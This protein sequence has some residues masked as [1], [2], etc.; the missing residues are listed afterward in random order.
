MIQIQDVR[1]TYGK[2][3]ALESVRLDIPRG[4]CFGLVGPNGAGK[5]TLMKILV[6]VVEDYEGEVLVHGAPFKHNVLAIKRR[7][8]YVPQD[9]CLEETLTARDNLLFFGRL[10]GLKGAKL[11][12][13]M[14]QVLALIG[15][16]DREKTLVKTFSGGMKRRLNIG[17]ALLH[18]PDIIVLDEP[19]VGVDPQ[20]RRAI[21]KLIHDLKAQDKTIL[22]SSHYMEEVE[23]LCDT[24]G[25]IDQGNVVE[26]GTMQEVL[27]KH[28][29]AAI[30]LEGQQ[31]TR[32][33]LN[34]YEGVTVRDKG[35]VI[36][37]AEPLRLLER[38]ANQFA[39]E[40]I[41]PERLELSQ[42]KL[43]DI[44][45]KLTGSPLRDTRQEGIQ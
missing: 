23:Q 36:E 19:T 8:G 15:L 17:C 26:C 13:R 45:F 44:F 2:R 32:E 43:E 41:V 28:R 20:S 7:I 33:R 29:H 4:S 39:A 12:Q 1:K 5:S 22:Y 14:Q 31:V 25:F 30:Y 9:I 24:I 40:A 38:L 11:R 18:D 42:A 35:F 10:Y 16:E 37:S 3:Q 21:F 34:G 27:T 6:G